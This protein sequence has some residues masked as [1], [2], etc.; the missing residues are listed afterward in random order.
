M[1]KSSEFETFTMRDLMR[2]PHKF[3]LAR[4][5]LPISSR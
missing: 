1:P 4:P 3:Y 5:Q 2:V